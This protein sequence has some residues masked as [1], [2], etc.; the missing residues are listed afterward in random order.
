MNTR[1][2]SAIPKSFFRMMRKIP[3]D[4]LI[5]PT[6]ALILSAIMTWANVGFGDEFF[7]KWGRNFITSLVILPL[8]LLCIGAMER[9]VDRVLAV[10]HWMGRKLVVA[11]LTACAIETVLALA[12]TLTSHPWDSALGSFW[13]TAFSRS[14]PAGMLIGLFMSFY[15]KPK[16][17]RMRKAAKSA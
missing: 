7:S 5:L 1:S 16:M 15:M 9:L 4:V 3:I 11:L 8:V 13:W 12:V 10:V 2:S 6:V 17:D 14:L